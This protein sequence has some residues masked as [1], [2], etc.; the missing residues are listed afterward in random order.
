MRKALS[1]VVLVMCAAVS[2]CAGNPTPE[3]D[4]SSGSAALA[5]LS[6]AVL[7]LRTRKQN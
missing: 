1:F 5:L 3:M 7:V 2:A 6:G 4:A